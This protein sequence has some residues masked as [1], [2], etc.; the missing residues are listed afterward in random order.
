[1][2]LVRS[3]AWPGFSRLSAS[4][5]ALPASS[6]PSRLT[7][8]PG[9]EEN[10]GSGHP[11]P[12]KPNG[13][14]DV[15]FSRQGSQNPARRTKIR[16]IRRYF[17]RLQAGILRFILTG[18]HQCRPRAISPLADDWTTTSGQA[19]IALEAVSFQKILTLANVKVVLLKRLLD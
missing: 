19:R 16:F 4:S 6:H 9:M 3:G 2:L 13:H 12:I 5:K 8:L 7:R 18:M 11:P 17:C 14:A 15:A 10:L 1:M